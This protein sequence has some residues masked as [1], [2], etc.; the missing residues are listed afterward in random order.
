MILSEKSQTYG[1]YFCRDVRTAVKY[2]RYLFFD[3][4]RRL[5]DVR[6]EIPSFKSLASETV[7]RGRNIFFLRGVPCVMLSKLA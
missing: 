2:F 5:A 4:F 3:G 6:L 1:Q 7:V